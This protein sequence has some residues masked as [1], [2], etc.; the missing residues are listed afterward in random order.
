LTD[1]FNVTQ[2]HDGGS[3]ARAVLTID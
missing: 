2:R 1:D 3:H